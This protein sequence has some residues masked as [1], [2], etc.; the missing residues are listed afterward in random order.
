[1]KE[2]LSRKGIQFTERDIRRDPSAIDELRRIG[3]MATPVVTVDGEAVVGFD[4]R[5]I[6]TLL[7]RS[8]DHSPR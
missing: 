7:A 5:R 3:A 6:D 8:A 1:V 4:Q 2:Y